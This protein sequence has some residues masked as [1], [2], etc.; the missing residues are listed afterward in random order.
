MSRRSSSCILVIL[1]SAF[2]MLT[3][4]SADAQ[5]PAP[6]PVVV[7]VLVEREGQQVTDPVI[8][9]LIETRVGRPLSM[10]DVRETISHLISL[11]R[12]E[13]VQPSSEQVANGIRVRWALVPLHPVDRIEF[14][15]ATGISE[16]ALRRIV[17]ER[18][19]GPPSEGRIPDAAELL[20]AHYRRRGY[21][22]ATIAWR[23]EPTHDPDRAT[24]IFNVEAGVR[25][26][27]A[28]VK[29]TQVDAGTRPTVAE[30]PEIKR[31]EAYDEDELDKVLQAWENRMHGRGYYEARAS[32][33]VYQIENEAFVTVNLALGPRVVI[34]FSGDP[35]P[36]NEKERLVPVKA[37]ASADEDL[38]EDASRAIENY[39][40]GR[41]YRDASAPYTREERES[42]LVITFKVTSGPRFLL[43]DL[44]FGGNTTIPTSELEGLVRL[45]KGDPF[46][47][48]TLDAGVQTV[49]NTYRARGFTRAQVKVDESLVAPEVA[50]DPDRRI[51]IKLTIAE[52]PRTVI[53]AVTF[54]GNTAIAEPELQRMTVVS[55]GRA[56]VAA[57]MINDRDRI[58]TEYRNRGYQ[59]VVVSTATTLDENDTQV[60]VRFSISEGPQILVDHIIIIGNQRT[61]T[62]TIA[63]EL[64]I[65]EGQPLGEAAMAESRARLGALSL[66]RRIQME[67]IAHGSEPRRDVLIR[68]EES[69]PT[70]LGL[71][72]GVEGGY[73][74]RVG[75]NGLAEDQFELAPRGFFQIGR[76]NLFGK[77]RTVNLLTRVSLRSRDELPP[78][79]GTNTPVQTSYGFHEYRVV[80][81]YTEPRVFGTRSNLQ[82]TGILE[83]AIRT[84]FN[85]LR[86]EVRAEVDLN[87]RRRYRLTGYYSLQ[88]TKLFDITDPND[89]PLIDRLF[90]T[91]RLS[92][93]SGTLNRDTRDDVLD[94]SLGT[95][96]AITTDVAARAIGSEV[97]YIR[98]YLEG[99]VYRR[100]PV[101]RRMVLATGVRLGLA[102]GFPRIQDNLEVS[103]LPASERFFA[104]GDNSVRGFPLDRLVNEQTITPSGFPTGGNSLIVL[105]TEL[106]VDL[107]G[108]LQAAGFVDAGNVYLHSSDLS[109]VDLRP[110][111]G[112]G[113]MYRSP[114]G[115]IRIDLGFNL[116]PRHFAAGVDERGYVV[117]FQ[118]GQPF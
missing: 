29:I 28:D 113:V 17:T 6:E 85:F 15:G 27:V 67:P 86:R 54:Q 70:V 90:P 60:D 21:P 73:Q 72:G 37:E 44:Q 100:L 31:G 10:R 55:V 82:I 13:D 18:Y 104:G 88:R 9:S 111:A 75:E 84:S 47:R 89:K 71:G 87:A 66:F 78:T 118:L 50:S 94:P 39:L 19:G 101:S 45:K 80:P 24:L 40:H 61:K 30:A 34:A 93:F 74:V 56:Y 58:E 7:E 4:S 91:V 97:G 109:L 106:R 68:V 42:E 59:N 107:F 26:T 48:A 117:H 112:F 1:H 32:R 98:T 105:N 99:F 14:T 108:K 16:G 83:Q 63:D 38:L 77:N 36:D 3:L 65:K 8:T 35:I 103:D 41:G 57:E 114:V 43:R 5:T 51:E 81:S 76:R 62:R 20:R 96:T 102:H 116:S 53:R 25:S 92:K 33:A 110:A 52:G 49:M 115:P 95:R 2:C 11:N 64:L 22:K 69:P 46:V 79:D 23:L 12:F